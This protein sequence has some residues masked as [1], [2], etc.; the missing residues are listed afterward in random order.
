MLSSKHSKSVSEPYHQVRALPPFL[1]EK[2]KVFEKLYF[3]NLAFL[4]PYGHCFGFFLWVFSAFGVVLSF[5]QL[6]LYCIV[7][8][9]LWFWAFHCRSPFAAFSSKSNRQK[10]QAH[11]VWA[12]GRGNSPLF[13]AGNVAWSRLWATSNNW[14]LRSTQNASLSWLLKQ[15]TSKFKVSSIPSNSC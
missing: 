5:W 3:S 4:N 9:K 6:N 15:P 11:V 1:Q 2:T 8:C 12:W 14:R 10:I 7:V 13:W